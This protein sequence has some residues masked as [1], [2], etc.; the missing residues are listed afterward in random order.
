MAARS[1]LLIGA[2]GLVGGHCLRQLLRDEA[3]AR[4]V[5]LGRR[6]QGPD[7]PGL[8]QH[9]I[10]FGR[11]SD[12]AGLF[13]A[14]DVFCCL[15]TTMRK[16]G[17]REAFRLVDFTY[18]YEAAK[19]AAVN[20]AEQLL[21]VSSTGASPRSRVFYSRVKGE[22]EETVRDLPFRAVNLFR[23]SLLL[24][25]REESRAGEL[26][27]ERVLGLAS[28]LLAG[29]LRKYRPVQARKV[30][31]AMVRVAKEGRSG[32]HVFESDAVESLGSE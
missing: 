17:S 6:T 26:L 29:P 12:Y 8:E 28:F 11:L 14:H 32:F 5:T 10:D 3:Y 16:A 20:G 13:D 4:V 7:R 24:G 25:E 30:A 27:A 19:L 22:L 18:Q 23:P 1:A 15:G 21:L 31:A 9:A 2:T